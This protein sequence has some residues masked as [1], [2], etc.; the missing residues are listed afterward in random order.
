MATSLKARKGVLTRQSNTLSELMR[1]YSNLGEPPTL[2]DDVDVANLRNEINS[3]QVHLRT[4]QGV[5]EKAFFAFTE[6]VD[7]LEAP[8]N[9]EEE[10][11]VSEHIEKASIVLEES[12]ALL[13][14]ME[15]QK[16][17]IRSC[18]VG[19]YAANAVGTA[20]TNLVAR[21]ELPRLPIPEF[22][23][24]SWQWDNFWELFNA[25][26]HSLPLSN[27]QKFNYL[28]KALKGEARETAERYQVTSSN[29]PLLLE[30]LQ[31][32]YGNVTAIVTSLHEKLEAWTAKSDSLRDQ[33]KLFDQIS[34]LTKQLQSKGENLDSPWLLSKILS[35]FEV[36][37]QRKVLEKKVSL[38]TEEVWDLSRL[39]ETLELVLRQ[40]EEIQR[41]LPTTTERRNTPRKEKQNN[42]QEGTCRVSKE[43]SQMSRVRF[44]ESFLCRM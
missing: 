1:R 27:L 20:Q 31:K 40:E 2:S 23:G 43:G 9:G 25:T 16:E 19:A 35:K 33:C 30:Y 6:A 4:V 28:L 37:I 21:V 29:Y 15:V 24:N 38:P 17:A 7:K 12:D 34:S 10:Q 44:R 3:A 32:K 36:N 42:S 11:R 5:F 26:V 14:Q 41:H 18:A 13:A 39:M 8:L 22:S